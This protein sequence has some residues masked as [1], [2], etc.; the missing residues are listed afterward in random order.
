MTEISAWEARC[1]RC[2]RC[3]YEKI[4]DDAGIYYT[5]V[6][7]EKLD[8]GSLQCTVY[9]TR[10]TSRPGCRALTPELVARGLLPADCPYV[11]ELETY[12]APLPLKKP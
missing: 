5:E 2:G 1:R 6:A 11:A 8:L 3:C 4:E 9:A 12:V 7:C 10:E